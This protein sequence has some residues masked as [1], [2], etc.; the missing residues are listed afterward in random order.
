MKH[1]VVVGGGIVAWSAAAALRRHI[2]S[3][4]VTLVSCPVPP[5]SLADRMISTLPSISGFHEDLG[6]TEAD[7]VVGAESGLRIGT[8]LRGLVDGTS[9][10]CP[11]LRELRRFGR[12]DSFPSIVA[13]RAANET[14]ARFDQFSAAAELG[15]LGRIGSTPAID[16][17]DRLWA[18]PD[19]GALCSIDARFCAAP[20][21]E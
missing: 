7:T 16:D 11:C 2:P 4:E 15:R 10:L 19:A 14:I 20:G 3:L 9:A 17:F 6:L 5:G 18:A 12:R 1:V 13:S 8:A 21:S